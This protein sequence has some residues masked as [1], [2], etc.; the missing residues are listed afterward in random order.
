M[1]FSVCSTSCLTVC[2]KNNKLTNLTNRNCICQT[3]RT[4]FF[5]IKLP[6]PTSLRCF[7]APQTEGPWTLRKC[8][9]F[10][11]MTETKNTTFKLGATFLPLA[12]VRCLF[13]VNDS[14][15]FKIPLCYHKFY[16]KLAG[17]NLFVKRQ[18]MPF[19]KKT[20]S[21]F[22]IWQTPKFRFKIF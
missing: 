7:L 20:L 14:F 18:T 12:K 9:T 10:S 15:L 4:Q 5:F 22:E 3:S 16:Y 1:P 2:T 11:M 19:F 17:Q 8:L 13:K 21:L 6:A